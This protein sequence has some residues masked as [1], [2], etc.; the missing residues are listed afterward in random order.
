VAHQHGPAVVQ[1]DHGVGDI[2][3]TGHPAD[4]VNEILLAAFD[5]KTGGRILVAALHRGD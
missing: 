1:A 2:L 5:V 4:A 3:Q